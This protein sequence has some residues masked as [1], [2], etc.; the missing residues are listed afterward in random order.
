MSPEFYRRDYER[1]SR[2]DDDHDMGNGDREQDRGQDRGRDKSRAR[3]VSRPA[4]SRHTTG[5]W[6]QPPRKDSA[7]LQPPPS[8]DPRRRNSTKDLD[9]PAT[10]ATES[11]KNAQL[12]SSQMSLDG[13]A[14]RVDISSAS[15]GKTEISDPLVDSVALALIDLS[16]R[17]YS[18]V[19][20]KEREEIV[21]RRLEAAEKVD[22]RNRRGNRGWTAIMEQEEEDRKTA[23]KLH[24]DAQKRTGHT[25]KA[26]A[27]AAATAAERIVDITRQKEEERITRL[28]SLVSSLTEDLAET[29]KK[30]QATKDVTESKFAEAARIRTDILDPL[31]YTVTSTSNDVKSL[32]QKVEAAGIADVRQSQNDLKS[33]FGNFRAQ[34]KKFENDLRS[35]TRAEPP[36]TT[37]RPELYAKHETLTRAEGK[38]DEKYTRLYEVQKKVGSDVDQLRVDIQRIKN[39]NKVR[40]SNAIPDQGVLNDLAK[41][42]TEFSELSVRLSTMVERPEFIRLY[43]MVEPLSKQP[44]SNTP[45]VDRSTPESL[46]D[47]NKLPVAKWTGE[48]ERIDQLIENLDQK[49]GNLDQARQSDHTL[50]GSHVTSLRA[51]VSSVRDENARIQDTLRE[52]F[53]DRDEKERIISDKFQRLEASIDSIEADQQ[54]LRETKTK[55]AAIG[56]QSAPSSGIQAATAGILSSHQEISALL[57][58]FDSLKDG[59]RKAQETLAELRPEIRAAVDASNTNDHSIRSLTQRYNNLTTEE[60]AN[61]VIRQLERVYPNA[62]TIQASFDEAWKA[63]HAFQNVYNALGQHVDKNIG[64]T[65]QIIDKNIGEVRQT[66]DKN[67]GEMRQTIDNVIK[68]VKEHRAA[69]KSE[70]DQDIKKLQ[71]DHTAIHTQVAGQ[72]QQISKLED[73][74]TAIRT[75]VAGQKQQIDKLESREEARIA[76]DVKN[77]TSRP[78]A[79]DGPSARTDVSDPLASWTKTLPG[80]AARVID[81]DDKSDSSVDTPLTHQRTRTTGSAPSIVN[82]VESHKKRKRHTPRDSPDVMF[83]EERS[84]GSLRAKVA[85]TG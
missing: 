12:I 64:E 37:M 28:E 26:L 19:Y 14:D 60:M 8:T 84:A 74:H 3:S 18:A 83:T 25:A 45:P 7:A 40:Q 35:Q 61:A 20:S 55:I 4:V 32:A 49:V 50:V 77:A 21:K 48:I 56:E 5:E 53:D 43:S 44:N 23:A 38:M 66:I 17:A 70:M 1:S 29:K 57:T 78:P 13:P 41:L 65:R 54:D 11:F 81:I 59:F 10:G 6:G 31:A 69:L 47:Q 63:I 36:S 34:W 42:K 9:A 24:E 51:E 68:K 62:S 27:I 76:K 16:T 33:E 75:Q 39:E 52:L 58:D 71:E 67:I 2:L 22:Q 82:G 30:L 15:R 73:G 80:S 72:R 79:V 85:K 46:D